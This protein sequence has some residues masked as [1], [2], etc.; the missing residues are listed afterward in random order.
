M[1]PLAPADLPQAADMLAAAFDHDPFFVYL[2]PDPERRRAWMR[3]FKLAEG[4]MLLAAGGCRKT[5]A[6][7][8]GVLVTAPPGAHP[9]PLLRAAVFLLRMLWATLLAPIGLTRGLRGFSV[10]LEMER[11]HPREPHWYLVDIAVRPDL[12]GQGLG[13][14]LLNECIQMAQ[15]TNHPIYLETT[16]EKNLAF[17]AKY[18]FYEQG[19][20]TGH[21]DAP[22]VWLLERRPA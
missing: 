12:H 9:P 15:T 1:I 6:S 3:R 21:G 7:L 5:D 10:L 18:G 13:G 2:Q 14:A 16:N 11:R 4:R 8:S 17:Y 20:I 22:P 19:R